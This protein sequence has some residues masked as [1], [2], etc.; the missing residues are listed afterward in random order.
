[1]KFSYSCSRLLTSCARCCALNCTCWVSHDAVK[2]VRPPI[3][4]PASAAK[5]ETY[6]GSMTQSPHRCMACNQRLRLE[7]G[8]TVAEKSA[9]VANESLVCRCLAPSL[10]NAR[11]EPTPNSWSDAGAEAIG[12]RLQ[13]DVSQP[14]GTVRRHG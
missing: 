5:A 11:G 7:E 2:D 10:P 1:M 13:C 8:R 9:R 12:C 3:V 4:D 6:A 14:R